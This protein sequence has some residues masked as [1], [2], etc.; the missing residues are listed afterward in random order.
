M[1]DWL[2]ALSIPFHSLLDL[3]TFLILSK[4]FR[5]AN[6]KGIELSAD[7]FFLSGMNDKIVSDEF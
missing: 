2:K 3:S 4:N 1:M 6:F 7:N 5:I